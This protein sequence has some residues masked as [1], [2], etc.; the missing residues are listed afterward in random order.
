M[1]Y[2][3]LVSLLFVSSIISKKIFNSEKLVRATGI[4]FYLKS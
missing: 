2:E 1:V 3:I 4:V